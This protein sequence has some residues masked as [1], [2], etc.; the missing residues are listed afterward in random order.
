[1]VFTLTNRTSAAKGTTV[2]Q[3]DRVGNL[4][5]VNYAVSLD[6]AMSYDVMNR[7][8]N[9]VDA[10][11]TTRFTYDTVGRVLSEDGP[12]ENDT[13]SYTYQNRSRTGLRVSAPNASPWIQS[14]RLPF[15]PASD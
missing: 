1:M 10:A 3:Y 6:I 15:R 13:V 14:Y 11:G 8:T 2:Y 7:L 4:T 9:M 12:W 5:N